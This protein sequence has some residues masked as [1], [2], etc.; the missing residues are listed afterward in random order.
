MKYFY[1]LFTLVLFLPLH[2]TAD[3][4][5]VYSWGVWENG[6]KP[7]AGPGTRV[8]PPPVQQPDINFRPNE[9][10]AFLREAAPTVRLAPPAI[11]SAPQIPNVVI[12]TTSTPTTPR[13][14][15]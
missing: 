10:S 1:L 3:T 2:A 4:D 15:F 11:A 12:T 13:D 5:S 7:A 9:N 6:I 14:Q 8:T